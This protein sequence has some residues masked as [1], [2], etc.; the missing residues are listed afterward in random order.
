MLAK[1]CDSQ[2]EHHWQKLKQLANLANDPIWVA[3]QRRANFD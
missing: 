3:E 2:S 1:A